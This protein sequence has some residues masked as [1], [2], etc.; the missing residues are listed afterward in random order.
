MEYASETEVSTAG[1]HV[2]SLSAALNQVLFGQE[3]LIELVLT[4]VLAAR[5]VPS[6]A[7]K[8]AK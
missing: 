5:G 3:E 8:A 1:K 4:G 6:T 7:G 2:R